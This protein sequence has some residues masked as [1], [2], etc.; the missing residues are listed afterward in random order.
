MKKGKI[1]PVVVKRKM[2]IDALDYFAKL[3]DYGRRKHTILLE[4]ADKVK[5]YGEKSIVCTEPCLNVRGIRESFE[6]TALNETG[7]RFLKNIKGDFGFCD[8]LKVSDSRITGTL[9]PKRGNVSEEERLRL[10][11]HADILRIIA[12][13]L[14]PEK[15][16]ET[17]F[18]GLF[19]AISYDFIDQ[20]EDLPPS[21]KDVLNEPDYEMNYYD[22]VFLVDHKAKEIDII[23]NMLVFDKADVASEK[24]RTAALISKYRKALSAK[25]PKKGKFPKIKVQLSTDTPKEQFMKIVDELKENVLNGDV[26]QVVPSRTIIANYSAE[27]LDIYRELRKLNP[28]PYMFYFNH[29]SG[30]L[31]G[32]SPEMFLKVQ[33]TD[34]KTVEISPIA[35]TK[36]RGMING[37]VDADL[38]SKYE[39]ELKL[40]A[41]ELAEHT[42]LIDL[43][44]NDIARVSMPGSRSCDEPYH[45]EKYSHVQHIVSHVQGRMKKNYDALHAY[46]ASMNMGT[47]TGAPKV[48]AMQL[49]RKKDATKRGFYGGSIG[50]LTPAGNFDSAIVIRSMS[51]KD[52]KAYVRAGAGIVYDSIAEN[53]FFETERKAAA[54]IKA[55]RLASGDSNG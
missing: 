5:K 30:I 26:V 55:I 31:L 4:S 37:E 28:S 20:F 1:I 49:I 41:K 24:K 29:G 25:L 21:K 12:F 34:G 47:L 52:G 6:I 46:L 7:R 11:T 53:E 36:P 2:Q 50:Y 14:V 13:K 32:S 3:S 18:A 51:L 15:N 38:D 45:I 8:S 17:P 43:A 27:P 16:I 54:A 19:G 22:S 33:G 39:A 44:R 42:M 23:A 9:K 10:R 40:D 48:K 35:G